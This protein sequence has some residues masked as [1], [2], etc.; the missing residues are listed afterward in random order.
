MQVSDRRLTS[1]HLILV[2][3]L[4]YCRTPS[5]Y[6]TALIKYL[7]LLGQTKLESAF[8]SQHNDTTS[9]TTTTTTTITTTTTRKEKKEEEKCRTP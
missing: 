4:I 6:L 3:G 8:Y 1:P 9:T 5:S 7:L 2:S